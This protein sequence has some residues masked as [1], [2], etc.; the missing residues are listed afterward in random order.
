LA[1][2]FYDE[3]LD[4]ALLSRLSAKHDENGKT[5]D[6]FSWENPVYQRAGILVPSVNRKGETKLT[7]RNS[8][9]TRRAMANVLA[10]QIN[11][12]ARPIEQ[13]A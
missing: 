4:V 1:R 9:Q 11:L 3:N 8:H 2:R 12:S 6:F 7:A 10:T 13:A 5:Y